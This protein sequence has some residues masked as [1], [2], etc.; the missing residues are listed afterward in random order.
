MEFLSASQGVTSGEHQHSPRT[1]WLIEMQSPRPPGSIGSEYLR[2]KLRK[3]FE[4]ASHTGD[5]AGSYSLENTVPELKT[6]WFSWQLQ[7]IYICS[8]S[9]HKSHT[10][11]AERSQNTQIERPDA[12]TTTF[13]LILNFTGKN[14][15][16]QGGTAWC[17]R[18]HYWLQKSEWIVALCV[19]TLLFFS[20]LELKKDSGSFCL[21]YFSLITKTKSYTQL[22]EERFI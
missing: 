4:Q 2:M 21:S 9:S 19:S 13:L 8:D 1:Y 10:W 16:I 15:E 12:F 20:F 3:L 11:D 18:L 6:G 5:P 14:L 22:K 17:P 7:Q